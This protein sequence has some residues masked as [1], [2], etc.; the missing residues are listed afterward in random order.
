MQTSSKKHASRITIG[1]LFAGFAL[2]AL[3]TNC[4][5]GDECLRYSDC[6]EG[7]TCAFGK[8]VVPPAQDDEGGAASEGGST[9]TDSGPSSTDSGSTTSDSGSTSDAGDASD[10]AADAS[11]GD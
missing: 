2:A 6:S 9:T 11:D 10:D 5:S 3:G 1:L 8:C 4:L 7:L